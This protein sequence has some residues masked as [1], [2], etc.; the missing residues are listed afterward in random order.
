MV[1]TAPAVAQNMLV[2]INNKGTV[3]AYR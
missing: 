3:T 2:I 1:T